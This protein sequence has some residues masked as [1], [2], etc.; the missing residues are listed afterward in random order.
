MTKL[1]GEGGMG[2]VYS[3]LDPQLQRQ[4]AIKILR[5][6]SDGDVLLGDR[7]ARLVREAQSLGFFPRKVGRKSVATK[8]SAIE[9][10]KATREGQPV[11]ESGAPASPSNEASSTP[12]SA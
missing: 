2:R 10:S 11:S 6:E 5:P 4:V 7:Q 1:L 9:K 8:M 12:K 3:A